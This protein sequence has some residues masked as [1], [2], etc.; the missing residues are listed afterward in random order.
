MTL[1]AQQVRPYLIRAVTELHCGV[2][3]GLD[4]IDLPTAKEALTGLP[5]V[6][7]STVKGVLRDHYGAKGEAEY[8]AAFGPPPELADEHASALHFTDARMLFLPVR[9]FS[10]VFACVTSPLVLRR[11]VRDLEHAD[12]MAQDFPPL[13]ELEV[14]EAVVVAGSPLVTGGKL[15]LEE[16]DLAVQGASPEWQTF[17]ESLLTTDW[18]KETVLPR[19]AIVHDDVLTF[20]CETALPVRA[21]IRLNPDSGTVA[22]GALWY[23]ESLPS[24]T[25]LFGLAMANA[26]RREGCGHDAKWFL[27]TYGTGELFLQFG[28]KATTGKGLCEMRFLDG[29]KA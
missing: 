28:G 17:F 23:E 24:E 5:V 7:G 26:S 12:G 13:P 19:L 2:G 16:L 14:R 8:L 3:Q 22:K 20:L 18:D 6:P 25:L 1:C 9:S 10:G 4:D 15:L 27:D 29:G 11:L 21:H